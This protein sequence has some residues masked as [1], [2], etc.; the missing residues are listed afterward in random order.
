MFSGKWLS[1][2]DELNDIFISKYPA[3]SSNTQ[4]TWETAPHIAIGTLTLDVIYDTPAQY[5]KVDEFCYIAFSF[6]LSERLLR[7]RFRHWRRTIFRWYCCIMWPIGYDRESSHRRCTDWKSS[8]RGLQKILNFLSKVESI[9][10]L[11][12]VCGMCSQ[13]KRSFTRHRTL[14]EPEEIT[15]GGENEFITLCRKCSKLREKNQ[16]RSWA[17][18]PRSQTLINQLNNFH[19]YPQKLIIHLEF[20]TFLVGK[21]IMQNSPVNYFRG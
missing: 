10:M 12:A 2:S 4:V 1:F 17:I 14:V 3:S 5:D 18:Q 13:E 8:Q 20:H 6:L 19:M 9:K 11:T 16:W 15:I 21:Y 7:I